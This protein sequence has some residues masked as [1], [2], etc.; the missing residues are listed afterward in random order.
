[1]SLSGRM[2]RS[3]VP[4][5]VAAVL[6]GAWLCA[7][8]STGPVHRP[9]PGGVAWVDLA[10]IAELDSHVT[11]QGARLLLLP[12]GMDGRR[13]VWALLGIGLDIEPGDHHLEVWA[14]PEAEAP[15]ARVPV[16]VGPEDYPTQHIHIKERR[17][18][19]PEPKDMERIRGESAQMAAAFAHWRA[20]APDVV[21]WK[22]PVLGPQ[23]SAFGLRRV[24]NGVPRRPHS[25][26]D[27]AA[28]AGTP[29]VAPTAGEVTLV[30][31]FFFNGKT[32][33]VDHGSG[34]ISLYCHLQ[35]V[36]VEPGMLLG[37]G[38]R[39]GTVGATGRATGPH[40]HFSV[41]L[42]GVRVNPA[43]FFAPSSEADLP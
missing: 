31:D 21:D 24:F 1:M 33:I 30:G 34:L 29:V 19:H 38:D 4:I 6:S 22:L 10:G 32:V 2:R 39:L 5:A 20:A 13:G 25:G 16:R 8:A 26:I 28:P 14:S 36:Q 23:S 9:V 41:N 42:N 43:L 12:H 35:S 7:L 15:T 3:L 27:W 40:L 18:V 17:K 11:F 37:P